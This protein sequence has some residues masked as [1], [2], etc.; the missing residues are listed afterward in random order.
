ML[1]QL[2]LDSKVTQLH[3]YMHSPFYIIFHHGHP[4]RLAGAP[5]AVEHVLTAQ[6][7]KALL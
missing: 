5:W 4:E 7:H 3:T 6:P 2:L 1:C